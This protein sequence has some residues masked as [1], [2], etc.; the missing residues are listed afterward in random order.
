MNEKKLKMKLKKKN[1][2]ILGLQ[3]LVNLFIKE[4]NFNIDICNLLGFRHNT[5]S[6]ISK[7]KLHL[8]Y[9]KIIPKS[10][11]LEKG[12]NRLTIRFEKNTQI[13]LK[14]NG[15]VFD[16]DNSIRQKQQVKLGT[17]IVSP[18]IVIVNNQEIT[19]TGDPLI[20]SSGKIISST[21]VLNNIKVWELKTTIVPL[22][23][24]KIKEQFNKYKFLNSK[25]CKGK[26]KIICIIHNISN[27]N[28][29]I[30]LST[31]FSNV[32][33]VLANE[34]LVDPKLNYYNY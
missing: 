11:N 2:Q 10:I 14:K 30:S 18:D 28:N 33:F 22:E 1:L 17:E 31:R 13:F 6:P 32:Y 21:D 19:I 23:K 16:T 15:I 29:L 7:I 4:N 20:I 5:N 9:P 25:L 3:K 12:D 27:M 24:I 26:S 34:F 8:S